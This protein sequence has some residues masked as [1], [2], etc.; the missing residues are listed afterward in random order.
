MTLFFVRRLTSLAAVAAAAVGLAACS[1]GNWWENKPETR[2]CP[3]VSVL[4]DAASVTVFRAGPGS[5]LTDVLYEGHFAGYDGACV[6]NTDKTGKGS[7]EIELRLDLRAVRGPAD[8]E[9]RAPLRI[10]VSVT[11]LERN[12]LSKEVFDT[13]ADF[14]GNRTQAK[15]QDQ[16]IYVTLPLAEGQTGADFL[17][18]TGF[19]ITRAQLE[20]NRANK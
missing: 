14:P 7:M 9:R 12:I 8:T 6:Y 10:F 5:D 13:P 15:L 2:P 3:T 18:F 20:Y 16:P 4:S 11:D 19:Q 17:I 1:A